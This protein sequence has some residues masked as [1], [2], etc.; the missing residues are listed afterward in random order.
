M[1][2][3]VAKPLEAHV[4][5]EDAAPS[6]PDLRDLIPIYIGEC[7]RVTESTRNKYQRQLIKYAEWLAQAGRPTDTYRL[8]CRKGGKHII[9]YLAH[10]ERDGAAPGTQIAFHV[11]LRP[12]WTWILERSLDEDESPG[13]EPYYARRNPAL[14]AEVKRALPAD[15]VADDTG[16]PFTDAEVQGILDA[17]GTARTDFW[18]LRDRAMILMLSHSGLRRG[19]LVALK[20]SDYHPADGSITVTNSAAKSTKRRDD[21]RTTKVYNSS[22][23]EI[24][25]YHAILTSD[26]SRAKGRGG[27]NDPLFPSRQSR[28]GGK[29]LRPDGLGQWFIKLVQGIQSRC[30]DRASHENG[31]GCERCIRFGADLHRFRATWAINMYRRGADLAD[32]M[33]AGGWSRSDMPM[34]YMRK[35]M[36]ELAL[37]RM[38]RVMAE[39]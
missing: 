7:F 6:A 19:E 2:A 4:N 11:A 10:M 17:I 14:L 5:A 28:K 8:G 37:E 18:T 26:K 3:Q 9:D 34:R 33:K 21:S 16:E 23:R 38:D 13:A 30:R 24:N 31:Q 32:I 27:A 35:A 25:R 22:H 15:E 1:T 12:F 39:S 29:H 36:G 20:V